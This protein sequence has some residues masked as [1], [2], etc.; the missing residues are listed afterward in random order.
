MGGKVEALY[1]LDDRK[2]RLAELALPG[3]AFQILPEDD[4]QIDD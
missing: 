2:T 4:A 3:A 1:S